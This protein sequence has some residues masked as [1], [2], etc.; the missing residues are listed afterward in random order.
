MQNKEKILMKHLRLKPIDLEN[1]NAIK[2]E[3]GSISD[4]GAMRRALYLARQ[5]VEK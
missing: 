2:E 5:V 3:S 1:L 4:S